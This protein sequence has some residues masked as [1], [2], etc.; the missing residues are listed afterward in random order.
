MA[1]IFLLRMESAYLNTTGSIGLNTIYHS[2][3]IH[4]E[5]I[6]NPTTMVSHNINDFERIRLCWVD[7]NGI[8]R[9]KTIPVDEYEYICGNG[10]GCANAVMEAT[11]EPGLVDNAKYGPQ[12]GD[13][14]IIP[15]TESLK[16]IAWETDTAVV[17]SNAT[18]I[19]G[20]TFDLCTRTALQNVVADLSDFGYNPS[21]GVEPEFSLLAPDED[22]EWIPYN[23]CYSYDMDAIDKAN[24]LIKQWTNAMSTAG[25]DVIGVHQESQPG[26]YEINIRHSDPL[27][28]ADGI[29][30]YRFMLKSTARRKGLK[31]SMMPRPYSSK[32]ANGM[33]L[34]VSLWD[35]DQNIFS[36][37]NT[38][39]AFP[40]GQRPESY[41]FS[42]TG[43]HFIGG[44]IE[45]MGAL[46]A[47]CAPTV[48]SYKRLVPGNW[49]PTTIAWGADNRSTAVR[50]PPELGDG[51]RI[52]Y[53]VPDTS[54]NPY[55]AIAATLAAG[56][57]GIKKELD[58]GSPVV[59]E[60]RTQDNEDLPRT[61]WS[62]L[63]DLEADDVLH[64][65]LGKSLIDEFIRIKRHEFNRSQQQVSEWE[66]D[67]YLDSF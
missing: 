28:T 5:S 30:F 65:T 52:E 40:A 24:Q 6:Q 4:I 16:P 33:H 45:H 8:R 46:T 25:Y 62:A 7:I 22:G 64:N 54:A 27:S 67:S 14:L 38:N 51:T 18:N 12:S 17:F 41:G 15:D 29:C 32:D 9:A 11:L 37:E 23:N 58:P 60:T 21:V 10:F 50:I 3:E 59:G 66:R 48:N 20:S 47:I 13:M 19:D 26:Q 56:L 1:P 43:R 44:I 49:A 2:S 53:R 61:L 34:H 57:D 55:L 42:E 63:N 35:G 31:T 39:L 36:S